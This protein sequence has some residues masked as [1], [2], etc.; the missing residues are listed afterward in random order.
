MYYPLIWHMC[1]SA[2]ARSVEKIQEISL[3]F[4]LHDFTSEYGVL[5]E[6]SW[7]STVY[8]FYNGSDSYVWKLTRP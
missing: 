2:D 6:K 3:R 8:T 5:M 7:K 4:V 1:S